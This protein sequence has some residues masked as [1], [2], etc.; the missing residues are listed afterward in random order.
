MPTIRATVTV[1]EA[2]PYASTGTDSTAAVERGVTVS[3]NPAPNRASDSAAASIGVAGV[4]PAISTQ[5][6]GAARTQP[7]DA[8]PAR[9]GSSRTAN[10]DSSAPSAVAPASA[11]SAIRCSS[12]PPY[13]TRSTNT[14]APTIAVAN[15]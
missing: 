11:P 1:D 6:D 14:A 5:R 3:P 2:A 12:G 7:A 4:Q 9:S 13:S 15:P 10:P 8:S